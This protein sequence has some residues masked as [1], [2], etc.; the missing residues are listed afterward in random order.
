MA[1]VK[2]NWKNRQ[3]ENPNRRRLT[4]TGEANVYD[5]AREEGLVLEE[6][7]AFSNQTMNDL[8]NR[9]AAGFDAADVQINAAQA[10]ANNAATAAAAAQSTA[11]GK[12]NAS[13]THPASAITAGTFAGQVVANASAQSTVG[14][15]QMR[16]IYAGT[17]DIGVGAALVTGSIYIVYEG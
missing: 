17:G 8:E 1:Y 11:N 4:A 3:S 7:D 16:N 6:G 9:I 2:K 14:T 13:H 15:A 12:A 10:T 5:V